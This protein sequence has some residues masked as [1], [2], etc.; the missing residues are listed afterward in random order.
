M[1][2][3]EKLAVGA[4]HAIRLDSQY[5]GLKIPIDPG[6]ISFYGGC[7]GYNTPKMHN[8]VSVTLPI[9][10]ITKE[11]ADELLLL[12]EENTKYTNKEGRFKIKT[13]HPSY[14]T[15]KRPRVWIQLSYG[16]RGLFDG[17][18]FHIISLK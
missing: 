8:G 2:I 1:T 6:K 10:S 14:E 5:N 11:E 16:M 15:D 18:E 12:L 17:Q 9:E 7:D 4:T 13:E 3:L